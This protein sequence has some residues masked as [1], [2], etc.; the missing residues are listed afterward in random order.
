[1]AKITMEVEYVACQRKNG[2]TYAEISE[3]LKQ[4]F[5]SQKGL[6]ERSVRRFCKLHRL[7]KMDEE[8]VD[9]VVEQ[10]VDEVDK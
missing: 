4:M 1:M 10:A 7:T 6:S 8:E 2:R 9:E 3:Q 5:P